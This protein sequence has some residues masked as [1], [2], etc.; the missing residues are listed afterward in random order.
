MIVFENC[1][2]GMHVMFLGLNF[3]KADIET[4]FQCYLGLTFSSS[5]CLLPNIDGCS[6]MHL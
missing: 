5:A 4:P 3:F 6:G 2:D 1:T